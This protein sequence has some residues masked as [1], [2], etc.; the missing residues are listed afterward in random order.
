MRES[1]CGPSGAGPDGTAEATIPE[2][3]KQR[4]FDS[5]GA[6][7]PSS[8]YCSRE[9]EVK[10][11]VVEGVAEECAVT[12]SGGTTATL[13]RESVWGRRFPEP[14]ALVHHTEAGAQP[15]RTPEVL[16]YPR[17]VLG[18][19]VALMDAA[20]ISQRSCVRFRRRSHC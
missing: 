3:I 9:D 7:R 12:N 16:H 6:P 14:V 20:W 5:C 10:R 8:G 15:A 2:R 18:S 4:G 19:V 11:D 1:R 13:A 17:D